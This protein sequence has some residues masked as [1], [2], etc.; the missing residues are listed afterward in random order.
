[1]AKKRK[2]NKQPVKPI[3]QVQNTEN[4]VKGSS[5]STYFRNLSEKYGNMPMES[6]VSAWSRTGWGN[7]FTANPYIQNDR[8]RKVSS[9]PVDYP[10]TDVADMIMN[11]MGSERGLREVSHALEVSSYPYFKIRKTYQDLPTYHWYTYPSYLDDKEGETD[12]FKRE[13]RLVQ[14]ASETVDPSKTARHLVG[15]AVQEG[16]S[17][18]ILRSKIDKAHNKPYY[19]FMQQLPSD[20]V[21][22]VG[23]NNV[24]GYTIAFNL[25]Y[26]LQPGT[27]YT[28]FGDLFLPYIS[29]F[30]ESI[31]KKPTT[32]PNVVYASVNKLPDGTPYTINTDK[33]RSNADVEVYD[34]NGTWFY[35]A[36]LPADAVWT[37]EIDSCNP[38]VIPP[39][40]G[41]ML[42]MVDIAQYE[43]I[44][45]ALVQNPLVSVLHGTIP[46]AD[47]NGATQEDSYKLSVTG[48]AFF[49]S[50]WYQML[51]ANNTSG[52]GMYAAPLEDMKLEQL[53]EAPNATQI[54]T[55]GSSYAIQKSGLSSLIPITDDPRAG[56]ANISLKIESRFAQSIYEQFERMMNWWFESFNLK[57]EFKF[58]MFGSLASDADD[59]K[60][61]KEGM[62]LGILSDTQ[63][64]LAIKGR[65]ILDD[66]SISNAII[67]LGIMDKRLPLISSYSAKN[68][69]SGLPP[70][71]GDVGRPESEEDGS[72]TGHEADIDSP[73]EQED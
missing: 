29:L 33:I 39:T 48:R 55:A 52:I 46:Y 5:F 44:Q 66:M 31:V 43:N 37:F 41:L 6:L 19:A 51:A 45:L 35:W 60:N 47:T 15:K 11:P 4:A 50:L 18:Y 73:N 30:E 9:L 65:S 23:F 64:Y 14:K 34:Q 38:N 42:A 40:T 21:K 24:T 16:K 63:I 2:A 7:A 26:F 58:K 56:L 71:T 62:T 70:K 3:Q 49:E 20:W 67:G 28:Q 10:R 59:L 32:T 54:S 69:D 72:S 17:F 61:A 53:A 13:W 57:H 36:T 25:M 12:Q 8:F 27:L 1:M 68:P 22:I